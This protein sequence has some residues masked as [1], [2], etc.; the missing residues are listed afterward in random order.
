MNKTESK[1]LK[2]IK[3]NRIN[4]EILG[5]RSW[6]NYLLRV[7]KLIWSRNLYDGYLIEVYSKDEDHL[8]S[9]KI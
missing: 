9:I 3:T 1:I 7:T 8:C 4:P 2:A 6:Y 5:K